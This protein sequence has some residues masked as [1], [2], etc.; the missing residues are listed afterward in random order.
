MQL[1]SFPSGGIADCYIFDIDIMTMLELVGARLD[2][3]YQLLLPLFESIN[4]VTMIVFTSGFTMLTYSLAILIPVVVIVY[5]YDSIESH[6]RVRKYRKGGYKSLARR[7]CTARRH[8][9][10]YAQCR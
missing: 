9:R 4:K 2:D 8:S 5:I 3:A 1:S 6:L 7:P 10:G